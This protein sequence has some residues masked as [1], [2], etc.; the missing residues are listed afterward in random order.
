MNTKTILLVDDTPLFLEMEKEFFRREPANVLTAQCG[1]EA[2]EVIQQKKPNLVF[3]DLYMANGN[4]DEAC[5]E[6]KKDA[7]LKQ[8]PIIM[9]TSSTQPQDIERC[10]QA[11]CDEMIHKP[12]TRKQFLAAVQKYLKLNSG[13]RIKIQRPVSY[14]I[15]AEKPFTGRLADISLG[16]LFLETES[17]MPVNSRLHL[18]FQLKL[19]SAPIRCT[20][21]VAWLNRES[22][23]KRAGKPV[24]MGIEFLELRKLDL[25][26]IQL[27]M[28]KTPKMTLDH[29][30]FAG[31]CLPAAQTY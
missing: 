10:R 23:S 22:S 6:I 3:M 30:G 15:G 2:V 31:D 8:I 21:R 19:A 27:W 7:L 9:V 28:A 14:G 16:G 11:G 29:E 17:L 18:E 26:H 4:G 5:R 20:G 24:G 1:Q 25:L 12:P 13:Q